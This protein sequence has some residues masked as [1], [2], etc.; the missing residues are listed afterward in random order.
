MKGKFIVFYGV[1]GLGKTTQAKMVLDHFLSKDLRAEYIKYPIYSL[2]SG[3]II[4]DI[5]RSG[6]KQDIS[7]L[8]FQMIYTANRFEF[9]P[10][11]LEKLNAGINIISED[12][13]GT[14]LSWSKAKNIGDGGFE[15]LDRIN[16]QLLPEDAVILLDGTPFGTAI[17]KGHLHE[18]NGELMARCRQT[19]L[20]VAKI[21]GWPKVNANQ[22][23]EKVFSDIIAILKDKFRELPL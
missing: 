15:I 18:T 12:Y 22:T 3:K 8:A 5:L 1:N 23:Q 9:Q 11:L 17:E 4:N 20:E 13:V 10:T 16:S 19:H 21:K 2:E 14:S 7:E 6:K